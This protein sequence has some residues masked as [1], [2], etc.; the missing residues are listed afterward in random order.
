MKHKFEKI[1]YLANATAT[2][3]IGKKKSRAADRHTP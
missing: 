3:M 2:S 1:D